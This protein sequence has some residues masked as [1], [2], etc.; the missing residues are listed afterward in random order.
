MELGFARMEQW[1][2]SEEINITGFCL[3]VYGFFISCYHLG[4]H[5]RLDPQAEVSNRALN[6]VMG[7]QSLRIAAAITNTFKH[8]T[9][10]EG[11]EARIVAVSGGPPVTV[12]IEWRDQ[13]LDG[14]VVAKQAAQDWKD[15]FAAQGLYP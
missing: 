14:L 1:C 7:T 5:I 6:R 8:H 4:E 15:F 3:D 13:T 11:H 9:R 12:T 10:D 2:T